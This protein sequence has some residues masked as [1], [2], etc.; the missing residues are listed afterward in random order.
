[1]DARQMSSHLSS[2]AGSTTCL[3]CLLKGAKN[4]SLLVGTSLLSEMIQIH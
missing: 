2:E 4:S 1:M 3:N